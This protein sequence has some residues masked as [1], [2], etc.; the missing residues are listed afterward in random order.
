[1]FS[2][3]KCC[4]QTSKGA[5]VRQNEAYDYDDEFID[6]AEIVEMYE[7]DRR[8]PK[9]TGFYINVVGCAWQHLHHCIQRS[10]KEGISLHE[11]Q[12]GLV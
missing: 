2:C 3:P 11:M 5:K 10:E 1:M 12:L 7:G 6:D 9:Q 8:K 4:L